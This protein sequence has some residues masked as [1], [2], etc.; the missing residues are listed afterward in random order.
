V[1]ADLV[2]REWDDFYGQKATLETGA[3][4]TPNGPADLFL[5]GN[6]A[7]GISREYT[8]LHTSFRYRLTDRFSL[9]ANYTLSE[10]EGNFDGETGPSGPI[11]A[12]VLVKPEY[13]ETRWNN[14]D[15][16]LR[17]DA[18]HKLRAWAIYDLFDTD[19]HKLSVSWLE[20]YTSGQPYSANANINPAP[21][22]DNPGYVTEDT[23]N[24]Y[25]FTARDALHT[26]D[27]HRS[28]ISLNYAF[29][30]AAWGRD[31]EVFLQPEVLNVFNEDGV[32]DPV[33]LDDAEGIT[34]R[35]V[36]ADGTRAPAF[37]PF[38]QTPVEGIDWAKSSSFGKAANENDFQTPRT[39]RFSVGF[40]F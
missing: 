20:N 26:D 16:D 15:G 31:V 5:L 34:L 18:R 7:P 30:F 35:P 40:R 24:L 6:F 33:G 29:K 21:F 39:F 1:R 10:T 2:H 17:V 38:T 19:H 3:V 37:N 11:S 23:S 32:F 9:S 12:D 4:D 8:G 27:I 25:Y 13:R 14:P 22:V 36:Q 28:D